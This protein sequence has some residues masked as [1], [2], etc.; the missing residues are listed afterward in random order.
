ML[1]I[2]RTQ[3]ERTVITDARG[4]LVGEI[5]VLRDGRSI[6]LGLDF[7]GLVISRRDERPVPPVRNGPP[8]RGVHSRAV[9][10]AC[11][12]T[13]DAP[14][15]DRI[16][17]TRPAGTP[18]SPAAPKATDGPRGGAVTRRRTPCA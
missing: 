8:P 5:V 2:T 3:G 6:R 16:A 9:R 10:G 15:A 18:G 14:K 17:T 13:D 4:G 11:P 7:P 1:I 12:A